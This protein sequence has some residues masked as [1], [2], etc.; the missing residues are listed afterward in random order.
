MPLTSC[1]ACYCKSENSAPGGVCLF[2]CL[3]NV[4]T[5]SWEDALSMQP[6]HLI[7]PDTGL[8]QIIVSDS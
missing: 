8:S 5:I 4:W 3:Q 1:S 6:L 7:I 2:V